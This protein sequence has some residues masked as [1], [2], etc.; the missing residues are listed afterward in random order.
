MRGSSARPFVI[1]FMG[2][3]SSIES[4][5]LEEEAEEVWG[6]TGVAGGRGFAAAASLRT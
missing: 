2:D 6:A 5:A 3:W 1:S 4:I